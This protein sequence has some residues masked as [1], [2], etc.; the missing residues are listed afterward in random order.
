M[1]DSMLSVGPYVASELKL[2]VLWNHTMSKHMTVCISLYRALQASHVF[3][4]KS[5]L[6][7]CTDMETIP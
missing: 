1:S 4:L 6:T 7:E 5:G 2:N 3:W